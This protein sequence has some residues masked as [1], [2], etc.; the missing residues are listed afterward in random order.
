M[1]HSRIAQYI[2]DLLAGRLG[3]PSRGQT[4][5]NGDVYV[6][7]DAVYDGKV[8]YEVVARVHRWQ[9]CK[10]VDEFRKFLRR[11]RY[12]QIPT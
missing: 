6:E 1:L 8:V 10:T 3:H 9:E 7:V 4:Y 2:T 12:R 11:G 5:S